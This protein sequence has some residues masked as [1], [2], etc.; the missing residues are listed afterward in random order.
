MSGMIHMTRCWGC[1][2][3]G[4][5]SKP[6]PHTWMDMDDAEHAG[7]PWPGDYVASHPCACVCSGNSD[8]H[9]IYLTDGDGQADH[10]PFSR[11]VAGGDAA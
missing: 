2:T 8:G 9:V 5:Y 1:M 6:T 7:V 11:G 4:C 3:D 10:D